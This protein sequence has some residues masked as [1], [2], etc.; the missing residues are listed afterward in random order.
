M[1]RRMTCVLVTAALFTILSGCSV[2]SHHGE[3]EQAGGP[4][5][6]LS[7]LPA[8]AQ[9]TIQKLIGAGEIRK[10]DK[11]EKGAAVI[12]DVEARVQG[13][14]VEYDVA[15]DGTVL[16]SEESVAF[17]S[18]PAAVRTAAEKH[19]GSSAG[20]KA[21]KELEEG[22]T[23]YEVEGGKGSAKGSVKLTDTG[24]IAEKERD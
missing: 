6:K 22:K 2:F 1:Q 13:K 7:D 5:L 18:L 11:E 14:D 24:A 23:F 10:L 21:S 9:A 19:F 17:A 12:Y 4:A 3:G 16:T 8:P 20:L 15:S